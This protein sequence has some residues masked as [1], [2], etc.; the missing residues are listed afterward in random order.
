MVQHYYQGPSIIQ[1]SLD[2]LQQ[3]FR[4]CGNAGCSD[5]RVFRQ[6]P[7]RTCDIRCDGC[8][9][10]IMT[11]LRIGFSIALAVFGIVV[12][13]QIVVIC[14]SFSRACGAGSDQAQHYYK[15]SKYPE[16]VENIAPVLRLPRY[17]PN[18]AYTYSP[19]GGLDETQFVSDSYRANHTRR[20]N[21]A[22]CY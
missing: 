21:Y 19:T 15:Y 8:H 3:A 6:D 22:T 10:R 17:R 7:P 18:L 2:R 5:F 20:A 1:E 12:F 14:V 9:F 4:C 13:A 11:A 16:Q